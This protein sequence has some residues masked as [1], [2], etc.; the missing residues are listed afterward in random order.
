[1][2]PDVSPPPLELIHGPQRQPESLGQTLLAHSD[3]A[4]C[5]REAF[6]EQRLESDLAHGFA[7][8]SCA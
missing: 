8:S 3:F 6:P 7:F 4:P 1:V 5:L 2:R